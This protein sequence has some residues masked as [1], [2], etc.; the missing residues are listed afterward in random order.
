[1]SPSWPATC[2]TK[3]TINRKKISRPVPTVVLFIHNEVDADGVRAHLDFPDEFL[4]HD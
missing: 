2:Q 1:M 4:H 3:R